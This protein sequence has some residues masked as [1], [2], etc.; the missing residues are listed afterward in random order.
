MRHHPGYV[1]GKPPGIVIAAHG[2][3]RR[4]ILGL[5]PRE[6]RGT[7][8]SAGAGFSVSPSIASSPFHGALE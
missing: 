7:A 8:L 3:S 6:P 2:A 4:A 5:T 1:I